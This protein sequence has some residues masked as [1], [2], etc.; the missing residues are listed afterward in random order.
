YQRLNNIRVYGV[1][2]ERNENVVQTV[3][4]IIN[5]KLDMQ[6]STTDIDTAHR[7][8]SQDQD[9]ARARPV[10]VR[11]L[12]RDDRMEVISRRKKL[13]GTSVS[14]HVD[15]TRPRAHLLRS[16]QKK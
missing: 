6:L 14:I 9:N 11:F 10:I 2:E 8:G 1:E 13:K 16:S 4:G 3:V 5:E 7:L 15:L 12:R